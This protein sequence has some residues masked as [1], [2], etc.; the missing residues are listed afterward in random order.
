MALAV[1]ATIGRFLSSRHLADLPHRLHAV[2]L[3]H[4]DVHQHDVD[5]RLGLQDA[6]SRR[7][8]CRPTTITMSCSSRTRRQ[9]E[10]VAHVVVH[11]QHLLAGQRRW[12]DW[13]RSSSSLPLR[14]GQLGERPVQEERGLVEQ[15]LRRVGPADRAARRPAAVQP[16]SPSRRLAVAVDDRPAAGRSTAVGRGRR[17]APR[18]P[19]PGRPGRSD[20]AVDRAARRSICSGRRPVGGRRHLAR[21]SPARPASTPVAPGRRPADHQQAA[22]GRATNSCRSVEQPVEHVARSGSAWRR[23]PARPASS[24]RSRASSVEMTHD[25]D[26]P[27]RQVVL[28]PLEHAP[29]VDVRQVDVERD[30]VAACTPGP[31]PGRPPRAT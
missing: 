11:D 24:A 30:G 20:H 28:E 10:D 16:P 14:L 22:A 29:A 13:C 19:G 25:R 4:H 1:T 12:S 31:A 21:P 5:V 18:R 3:R 23:T 15:P 6:R 17:P 26:V 7:G 27:R 2:H 8:R 9:G